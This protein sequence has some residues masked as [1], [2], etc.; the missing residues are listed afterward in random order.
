MHQGPR[1]GHWV[2]SEQNQTAARFLR[3][4]GGWYV[5]TTVTVGH[6]GRH[7]HD[8]DGDSKDEQGVRGREGVQA[9]RRGWEGNGVVREREPGRAGVRRGSPSG[10]TQPGQAGGDAA[11]TLE[12]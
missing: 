6:V 4:K 5:W 2:P 9:Q 1:H 12:P 10:V 7:V 11:V 8:D 3:H